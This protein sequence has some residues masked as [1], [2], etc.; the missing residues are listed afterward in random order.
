MAF[1]LFIKNKITL[2]SPT[3]TLQWTPSSNSPSGT[4]A[5]QAKKNMPLSRAGG[6]PPSLAQAAASGPTR[7]F[8]DTQQQQQ[9]QQQL[10]ATNWGGQVKVD[11]QTPWDTTG[12][13]PPPTHGGEWNSAGGGAN[14]RW[15][16]PAA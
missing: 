6:G 1:G 8:P 16:Q 5:D 3:I 7:L 9:Q 4:Y 11:Q 2:S 13:P 15:G 12:N 10:N 14:T